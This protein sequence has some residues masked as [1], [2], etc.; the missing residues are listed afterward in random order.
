MTEFC[1]DGSQSSVRRKAGA[2]S[3]ARTRVVPA[4]ERPRGVLWP[5]HPIKGAPV[6]PLLKALPLF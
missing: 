2:Q 1:E 6:A 4:R 3:L 5:R